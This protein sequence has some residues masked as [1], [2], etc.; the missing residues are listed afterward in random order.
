VGFSLIAT[1]ISWAIISPPHSD[2]G[3]E[4]I[5]AILINLPGMSLVLLADGDPRTSHPLLALTGIALQ[6]TVVG[7]VVSWLINK[8]GS[9]QGVNDV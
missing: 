7:T 1:F 2:K 8:L 4:Y 9:R 6:W 3:I 5:L